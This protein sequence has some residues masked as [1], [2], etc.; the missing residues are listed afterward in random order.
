MVVKRTFYRILP[1]FYA[2][3]PNPTYSRMNRGSALA[4]SNE[5]SYEIH[6]GFAFA[7]QLMVDM[8]G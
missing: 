7:Y 1:H 5:S 4:R 6:R 3:F 2:L 8:V